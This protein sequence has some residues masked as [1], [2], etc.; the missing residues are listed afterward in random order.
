ML[1]EQMNESCTAPEDTQ[2]PARCVRRRRT[3]RGLR[4]AVRL[5]WMTSGDDLDLLRHHGDVDAAAGLVDFAVNVR[6]PQPPAW[7]RTR[8]AAAIDRL[9]EYPSA[10]ADHAAREAVAHRHDRRPDEALV[11]AGAAE[12]FT[13]LAA[14]R[15]RSAAVVHPSFTEPE[16]ALRTAGVPVT[17]VPLDAAEGYRLRAEQVPDEADLVVVGNPTNPTSVLHPAEEIRRLLRPGRIVVVDEAFADTVPGEPESVA[18]CADEGL[19]VLRSLTKMWGLPGLRAGYALGSPEVLAR[20][21]TAR[22]HWPVSTLVLE[23]VQACCADGAVAEAAEAAREVAGAREQLRTELD[24][25]S[26]VRVV[27]PAAS[28]F[29]LVRAENGAK[30]RAALAERGIAVRRADTFPGL[31]ADH[32]RVA[33]RSAADNALLTSALREI[34]GQ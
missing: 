7:L 11:L 30:V 5:P 20:L 29:L 32:F 33:V 3:G 13:L 31:D 8:L 18:G 19:L 10:A 2:P 28:S 12:G 6:V 16:V 21:H 34:L 14:L 24:G 26:G 27:R 15:P 1:P 22:P 9:G 17:R 25:I 23:A 4:A